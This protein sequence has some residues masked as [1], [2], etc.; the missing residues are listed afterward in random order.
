MAN[1]TL[2]VEDG[3][4][5]AI[6][7]ANVGEA[8]WP[9]PSPELASG[10]F[11]TSDLVELQQGRV[12]LRGR[13]S[14]L[15]NVAGRKVSPGAIEQ[16]L[17]QHPSV[18]ASLVFGVPSVE[19]QRSETIVACVEPKSEVSQDTLR[20]FLLEHLP[21]WQVPRQWWFVDSL[22]ANSRGKISRAEWRKRFLASNARLI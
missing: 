15:I 19:A 1:V 3:G 6:H 2:T 20:Q 7:G 18:S 8:Y 9:E 13:A 16:V 4:C 14:D 11:L 21:A 12:F 5:L 22:T 10:R 17:Q